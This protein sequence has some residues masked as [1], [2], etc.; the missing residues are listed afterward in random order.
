MTAEE[1]YEKLEITSK[2]IGAAFTVH[3][4]LGPHYLEVVYQ[5]ALALEF[6]NLGLEFSREDKVPIYYKG[7]II[8]TRRADFI[9]DNVLVE[10]KAKAT[11]ENRDHEQILSYLKSS[12]IRIGLL[13][14]FGGDKLEYHRKINSA[15]NV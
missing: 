9:V 10:I 6:G 5:R 7:T 11:L 14:N 15:G 4:E 3:N 2:I 12:G 8:D 1:K 13:L